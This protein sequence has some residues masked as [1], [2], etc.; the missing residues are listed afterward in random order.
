MVGIVVVEIGRQ[1][2]HAE[3]KRDDMMQGG[4]VR[5]GQSIYI[6]SFRRR[7]EVSDIVVGVG[8]VSVH[9]V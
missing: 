5:D 2:L 8:V 7:V 6:G 4:T 1:S 9:D 3:L